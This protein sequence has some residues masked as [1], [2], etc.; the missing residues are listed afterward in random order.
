MLIAWSTCRTGR[1]DDVIVLSTGE[2]VV[3]IPQ[4]GLISSSPMASAAVMFGRGKNECGVLIEPSPAHTIDID[5]I[6]SVVQ[7]R[8]EIWYV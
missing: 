7:F 1:K 5:N 4:E 2:K 3:P 8:N 6:T